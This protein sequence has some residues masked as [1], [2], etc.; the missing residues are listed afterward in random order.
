MLFGLTSVVALCGGSMV[1][2]FISLFIGL[3]LARVG[4]DEIYGA[5]RFTFHVPMLARTGSNTSR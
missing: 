3:L 2:G 1:K 4:V 5:D